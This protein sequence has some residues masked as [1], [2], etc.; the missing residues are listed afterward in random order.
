MK[1]HERARTTE[2]FRELHVLTDMDKLTSSIARGIL[3]LREED[4]FGIKD[5]E[6]H[7]HPRDAGQTKLNIK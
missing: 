3:S 2:L 6:L 1:Q 4:C 7:S 5:S